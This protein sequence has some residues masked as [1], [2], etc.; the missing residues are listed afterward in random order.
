MIAVFLAPQN[1]NN[2]DENALILFDWTF[3]WDLVQSDW[4]LK[5]ISTKLYIFHIQYSSTQ[6]FQEMKWQFNSILMEVMEIKVIL[7]WI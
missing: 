4:I 1:E 5:S 6:T 7:C 2:F 3:I